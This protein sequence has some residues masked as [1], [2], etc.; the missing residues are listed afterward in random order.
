M[1][2][3]IMRGQSRDSAIK[4]KAAIGNRAVSF[5]HIFSRSDALVSAQRQ[6]VMLPIVWQITVFPLGGVIGWTC[7]TCQLFT[8]CWARC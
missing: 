8:P 6:V 3:A 4:V 1:K 7:G 5:L 2:L